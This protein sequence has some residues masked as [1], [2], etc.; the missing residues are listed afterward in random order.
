MN[1]T[2]FVTTFDTEKKCMEH[3]E[4]IRWPDGIVCPHCGHRHVYRYKDYRYRCA[5]CAKDFRIKTGTIFGDSKVS[6]RKWYM[7]IYLMTANKKGVSSVQLA[8]LIGVTQKTAWFMSH[9]LREAMATDSI[10]LFGTV[11]VDETYISGKNANRHKSKQLKNAHGRNLQGKSV[12]FGLAQRQGPMHAQVIPNA[13]V[14]TLRNNILKYVDRSAQLHTDDYPGYRKMRELYDHK[15]IDHGYKRY[16]D[17]DVHTNT[18]EGFWA[19][20]KRS[21][22]GIY[23]QMSKKHMQRYVD[24]VLFR[25]NG[26]G[27]MIGDQFTHML[28]KGGTRRNVSWKLLTM[29]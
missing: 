1:I 9:R 11:E 7:A 5:E 19:V 2:E 23:H 4:S 12:L 8:K 21:Y 15:R 24:E 22:Y 14:E 17:G 26:R 29:I 18:V 16:V 28:H 27:N 3:F 10:T 13:R 25:Y 20:F 6:L